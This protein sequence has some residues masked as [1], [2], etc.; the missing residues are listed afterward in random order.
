MPA[1]GEPPVEQ[2]LLQRQ[3]GV[4]GAV[5]GG[6]IWDNV[7]ACQPVKPSLLDI[8]FIETNHAY[9]TSSSRQ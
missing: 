8:T 6:G 2:P 3:L 9:A 4:I 7:E 5:G 1:T